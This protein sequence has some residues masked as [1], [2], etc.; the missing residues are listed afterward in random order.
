MVLSWGRH[1]VERCHWLTRQ[2]RDQGRLQLIHPLYCRAAI[3]QLAPKL[4]SWRRKFSV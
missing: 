2:L 3:H 1:S 4:D